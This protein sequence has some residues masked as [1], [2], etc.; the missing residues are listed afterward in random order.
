MGS[1][2]NLSRGSDR[3]LPSLATLGQTAFLPNVGKSVSSGIVVGGITSCDGAV[4]VGRGVM[5]DCE[6]SKG[7]EGN[8]HERI[9]VHYFL[10]NG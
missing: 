1:G 9:E 10:C 5:R 8:E 7:Q 2:R 3:R 6:S 4:V